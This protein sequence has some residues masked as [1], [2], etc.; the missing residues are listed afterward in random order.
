M[1]WRSSKG[2]PSS[3]Q[4]E[5]AAATLR[6][7]SKLH[8]SKQT[9]KPPLRGGEKKVVLL[10]PNQQKHQNHWWLEMTRHTRPLQELRDEK[11]FKKSMLI[12][13]TAASKAKSRHEHLWRPWD[14]KGSHSSESFWEILAEFWFVM[15][16]HLN[17][18]VNFGGFL[19]SGEI[20]WTSPSLISRASHVQCVPNE[21]E[22]PSSNKRFI[23][24]GTMGLQGDVCGAKCQ[25]AREIITLQGRIVVFSLCVDYGSHA[26]TTIEMSMILMVGYCGVYQIS[27]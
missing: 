12:R 2:T 26:T 15:S 14:R 10:E 9:Q 24:H 18:K 27:S 16:Q 19:Y 7:P 5:V 20:G 21:V 25:T 11:S 23:P 22:T 4:V 13:K 17:M 8:H 6:K 3:K 1:N